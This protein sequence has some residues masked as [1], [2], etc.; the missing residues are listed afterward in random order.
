MNQAMFIVRPYLEKDKEAIN[1][2]AIEAFAQFK[3]YYNDWE[4]IKSVVG[5]MA[6]LESISDLIVAEIN[7]EIVGAVALVHPGKDKNKNI[8]PSWASIRMLVVSPKH[9]SRGIGKQ[10]A[11]E[12]LKIAKRRCFSEIGLFTSPIMKVALPMYLRMGFKKVKGIEP[13]S[14]VEYALYKLEI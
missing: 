5:N 10:L 4:P 14:G 6:S 3:D 8:D 13:I 11:L 9:H 1:S 12:C 7:N 2:V